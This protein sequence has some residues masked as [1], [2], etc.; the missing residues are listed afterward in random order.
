[1]I[2]KNGNV[3]CSDGSF[4]IKDLLIVD[5]KITDD[6]VAASAD[7]RVYDANRKYVIPG[8][9]DIHSHGAV[10]HD[11]CDA[12]V[13]GL[14]EILKYEKSCG[15]TSYCPTS[16][17]LAKDML[18]DIFKTATEIEPSPEHA[19]IAGI[20]M[21]GPFI[22]AS[23]KGAQNGKYIY[24]PDAEFFNE[25]NDAAGGLIKLVTLAPEEAGSEEFIAALKDKVAISVGHTAATF[26]EADKAFKAGAN[27]VTHLCNGMPPFNH[28]E[29]GV[30][31]AAIENENVIVELICDGIHIH[32]AMIR[33]IFKLFGAERVALISDSMEATGMPD[34]D[35]ELGKQHVIK[36][37]HHATLEDGTLAGSATNLFDC[38]KKA[39][40]FGIP[41]T[42]A[43]KSATSTPAKSIGLYPEIGSLEPGARA[44]VLILGEDFKLEKIISNL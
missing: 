10:G 1:M 30:F 43:I 8:L 26:D 24:S 40:E 27:H 13:E 23:K 36:K 28:R 15:I 18:I 21:E 31:G 5:G 41:A 29:P 12:D 11:F 6:F 37:G 42:D 3:F 16:M 19:N 39:M 34:G 35:Y 22:S 20:N 9:V 38:M 7:G 4:Q 2:I 32:S 33:T 17:T 25:C 44:D 14:R